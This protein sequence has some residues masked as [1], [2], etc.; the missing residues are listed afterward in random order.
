MGEGFLVR[1]VRSVVTDYKRVP[2]CEISMQVRMSGTCRSRGDE[3]G[4]TSVSTVLYPHFLAPS[5]SAARSACNL[6]E[7]AERPRDAQSSSKRHGKQRCKRIPSQSTGILRDYGCPNPSHSLAV[8]CPC[9]SRANSPPA[10]PLAAP[11]TSVAS[12]RVTVSPRSG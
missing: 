12:T 10:F 2:C 1:S 8:A 7:S 11:A 6:Y 3:G 4:L 9:Q 5:C